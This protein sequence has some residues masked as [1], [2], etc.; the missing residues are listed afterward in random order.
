[1]HCLTYLTALDD[2][3]CLHTLADR[4]KVMMNGRYGQQRR[5][6][7]MSLIDVAV[8]E[9]DVVIAVVNTAFGVLAQLVES[10]AESFLALGTLEEDR[11]FHG[12]ET[13]IANVA[14]DV[15]LRVVQDRMRQA[16]HLTVGLVG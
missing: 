11:Q 6:G 1:M 5:D 4:D 12:V 13:L 3:G 8:A 15:E 7:G 16:H 14:E 2:K 9:N 10:V